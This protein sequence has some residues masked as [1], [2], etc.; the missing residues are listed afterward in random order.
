[1]PTPW[2]TALAVKTKATLALFNN[3]RKDALQ[4]FPIQIPGGGLITT[5][6]TGQC[7]SGDIVTTLINS[8]LYRVNRFE[9]GEIG[10]A[11]L[12]Y[13]PDIWVPGTITAKIRQ[14]CFELNVID[15]C[16]AVWTAAPNVTATLETTT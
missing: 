1:M 8:Q 13:I 6:I 9:K 2:S 7:D 16:D 10:Q 14:A 4:P 12:A 5:G 15:T 11:E 3:L